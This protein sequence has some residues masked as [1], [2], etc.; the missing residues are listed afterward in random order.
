[1]TLILITGCQEKDQKKNEQNQDQDQEI[2]KSNFLLTDKIK[3]ELTN[4]TIVKNEFIK[5]IVSLK[6]SKFDN[7]DSKIIIAIEDRLAILKSDLSNEKETFLTIFQNLEYDSV[8]R[9]Y[10]KKYDPKKTVVFGKKMKN[11]G[12]HKLKG[13][14]MEYYGIQLGPNYDITSDSLSN[15]RN[16]IYFEKVITVLPN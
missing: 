16:K 7:K 8:N 13:Y 9:K 10:F 6:T 14:V 12:S 3:I 15:Q 1:L 11:I 4:D 2:K 5:G